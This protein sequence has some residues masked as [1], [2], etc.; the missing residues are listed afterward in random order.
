MCVC[1]VSI[2]SIFS[3]SLSLC[4]WCVCVCFTQGD[5][6]LLIKLVDLCDKSL[7]T[8]HLRYVEND[9]Q[10]LYSLS[11]CAS[12]L[13][14]DRKV[15]DTRTQHDTRTP[16]SSQVPEGQ[17]V[18]DHSQPSEENT[19]LAATAEQGLRHQRKPHKKAAHDTHG[20]GTRRKVTA[21]TAACTTSPE[22]TD[23]PTLRRAPSRR[24]TF[25]VPSDMERVSPVCH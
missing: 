25:V 15:D 18:I 22:V 2:E 8:D 7:H 5:A 24:P 20:R 12:S 1:V 17:Q 10:G 21:T 23:R 14:K 11:P 3:L 16:V 4:V 19:K 6:P 9:L 13:N